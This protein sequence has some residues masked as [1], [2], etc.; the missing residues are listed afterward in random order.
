MLFYAYDRLRCGECHSPLTIHTNVGD[1]HFVTLAC[2]H[3][4][5][6][7]YA[8]HYEPPR[9]ELVPATKIPTGRHSRKAG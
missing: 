4:V 2:P 5:C 9:V 1:D 3:Q 8:V 7:Q 6:P